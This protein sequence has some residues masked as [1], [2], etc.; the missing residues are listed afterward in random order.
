MRPRGARLRAGRRWTRATVAAGSVAVLGAFTACSTT[1]EEGPVDDGVLT[2]A[3]VENGDILRMQELAD[4]YLADHPDVEIEWVTLPE[5][6]LRQRVTT[7]IATG[8]GQFDIVMLGAY[9]TTIWGGRDWLVPLDDMPAEYELDDVLPTVREALSLD[10][11]LYALPFYAESSFTMYRTDLFEAR[12][13]ELPEQPTWDDLLAAAPEISFSSSFTGDP[14]CLRG[15]PGWGE[16]TALITAMAN[17]YGGRWFDEE[18]TP[19]LDSEAWAQ[20]M[21]TYAGLGTYAGADVAEQG[22]NENLARFQAGECAI[23]VDATAAG[24]F[25]TDPEVSSVADD[26][27]FAAAPDAGGDRGSNWLWA[28]A[29]AIPT[30]SVQQEEARDFI[31]WATGP[32]Y[33]EL[34]A[35]E[36]GWAHVPPGTRTSLYENPD[37]LE[38]AP[39]AELTLAAIEAADPENPTTEPVPYTG[40]QYVAVPEFQGMGTAVGQ[41]FTDVLTGDR[42]PEEALENSQWVTAKIAERIRFIE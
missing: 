9:E 25:V 35:A 41:Q 20:T 30:S 37:Y 16:N 31:G 12:G 27:G 36:H 38:A 42:T 23:W 17:S 21:A 13:I 22:Y 32:E 14:F 7:D 8:A 15:K 4:Q 2:I 29:L 6:E 26:V 34:V 18:W 24:S 39:F 40:I 1:A 5:G 10:G 28:W 3:T 19:Q 11:S 33:S